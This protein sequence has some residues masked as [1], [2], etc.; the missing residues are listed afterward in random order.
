MSAEPTDGASMVVLTAPPTVKAPADRFTGDAWVDGITDGAGPGRARLATVRF[1]PGAR[2]SWHGHAH[3]QTLHV[4]DG[5]GL[6]QTRDG[7]TIVMRPGD[8]VYTPPGVWHWH[9]AAPGSFMTHLALSDRSRGAGATDVEWGEHV[10][11]DEYGTATSGSETERS[12]K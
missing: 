7:H 2:T 3:G 5:Q 11:D 8:T 6:V 12:P 1:S 4:T 9:G 10:S